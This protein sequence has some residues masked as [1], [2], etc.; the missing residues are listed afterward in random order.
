MALWHVRPASM[1]THPPA[2]LSLQGDCA[3]G[4][5]PSKAGGSQSRWAASIRAQ[6][7]LCGGMREATS[8]G[9]HLMVQQTPASRHDETSPGLTCVRALQG[10]V[11]GDS[12]ESGRGGRG[13]RRAQGRGHRRRRAGAAAGLAGRRGHPR[14]AAGRLQLPAPLPGVRPAAGAPPVPLAS[15]RSVAVSS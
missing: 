4:R 6:M 14:A 8:M 5:V 3:L 2:V 10:G 12:A 13:G 11:R 1:M 9:R 15:S 7:R